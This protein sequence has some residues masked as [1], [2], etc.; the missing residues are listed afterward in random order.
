MVWVKKYYKSFKGY[1]WVWVNEITKNYLDETCFNRPRSYTT[2]YAHKKGKAI[3]PRQ[4]KT[5][6]ISAICLMTPNGNY[7]YLV[8]CRIERIPLKVKAKFLKQL[9]ITKVNCDKRNLGLRKFGIETK[10]VPKPENEIERLFGYK[11]AIHR[12]PANTPQLEVYRKH[13][14][15]L[16]RNFTIVNLNEFPELA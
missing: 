12:L 6:P 3:R 1:K 16:K 10:L 7:A 4:Y 2:E 9:G 11:S 13:V 5:N 15:Y 14:E 8:R